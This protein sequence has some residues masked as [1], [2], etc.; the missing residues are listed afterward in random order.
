MEESSC[1]KAGYAAVT[2]NRSFWKPLTGKKRVGGTA[3]CGSFPSKKAVAGQIQGSFGLKRGSENEMLKG[4]PS[5][6]RCCTVQ[7][8]GKSDRRYW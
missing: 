4:M 8:M 2:E 3:F 6:V 5:G 1:T 7:R